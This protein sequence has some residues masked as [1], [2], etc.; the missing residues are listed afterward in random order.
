MHSLGRHFSIRQLGRT[1]LGSLVR[2]LSA[3]SL[4]T[5]AVEERGNPLFLRQFALACEELSKTTRTVAFGDLDVYAVFREHGHSFYFSDDERPSI[6]MLSPGSA[7][8]LR[9]ET[10]RR[11]DRHLVAG[12]RRDQLVEVF[13][14]DAD[15][16]IYAPFPVPSARRRDISLVLEEAAIP[17]WVVCPDGALLDAFTSVREQVVEATAFWLWQLSATLHPMVELLKDDGH[18]RLLIKVVLNAGVDWLRLGE[19]LISYGV[20]RFEWMQ[21]DQLTLRIDVDV[22]RE[23]LRS[24][25]T[26]DRALVKLL[27]EGFVERHASL[28]NDTV[29]ADFVSST[30]DRIA[31]LGRKKKLLVYDCRRNPRLD[32]EGLP[33]FRPVQAAEAQ[34]ILDQIGAAAISRCDGRDVS[35]DGK[36]DH[37]SLSKIAVEHCYSRIAQA[38]ATLSPKALLEFLVGQCERII[39][40]SARSDLTSPTQVACCG[41][42]SDFADRYRKNYGRRA[43]A[44]SACRFLIEYVVAQP[45]SGFRPLSVS[46]YDELLALASQVILFGGLDDAIQLELTNCRPPTGRNRR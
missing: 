46:V 18:D 33:D 8:Q 24:D 23:F 36:Q 12:Y 20:S 37:P 29:Q 44:H 31:P 5:I 1:R 27:L 4:E 35:V 40:E 11:I 13:R 38:V 19:E 34:L 15:V 10:K 22:M 14:V 25:N 17:I 43:E 28:V 39:Y 42:E 7:G 41:Q 3:P 21:H 9:R 6:V 32:P 26:G 2:F 16:P 30:I 45:P